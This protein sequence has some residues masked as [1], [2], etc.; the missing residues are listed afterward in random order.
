MNRI[1]CLHCLAALLMFPFQHSLSQTGEASV[2]PDT[3]YTLPPD[4]VFLFLDSLVDVYTSEPYHQITLETF[5][6]ETA[7]E[8]KNWSRASRYAGN[9]SRNYRHIGFSGSGLIYALE[10]LNFAEKTERK[11]DDIWAYFR[12]ANVHSEQQQVELAIS[13]ARRALEIAVER[14]T[15]LEIGWAYNQI[16]EVYR[17]HS[18]YDSAKV[19]YRSGIRIFEE[20]DYQY[21]VDLIT[22]NLAITLAETGDYETASSLLSRELVPL[23]EEEVSRKM[24][25]GIA[26][27]IILEHTADLAEAID[28]CDVLVDFARNQKLV[29]WEIQVLE[30]RAELQRKLDRWEDAWESYRLKDSLK[31]SLAGEKAKVQTRLLENQAEITA[32]S[33]E[34][35]LLLEKQANDRAIKAAVAA[36][37][38]LLLVIALLMIIS[39]RRARKT[40]RA[41]AE[42]NA[43]L[44]DFLAEK[45]TWINLMAHDLKAPLN[46]IQGLL[47]IGQAP[48]TP[49]QVRREAFG[50]IR[51]AVGRGTDLIGQLLELSQIESGQFQ[52]NDKQVKLNQLIREAQEAFQTAAD[53]K[54]IQLESKLPSDPIELCTDPAIVL[55]I[56]ENFLSNAIKFSPYGK[57]ILVSLSSTPE[58]TCLAVTDEGPGMSY[59]DQEKLFQKFTKLS[60]RPTGGESSTG[61]GLSIVKGL[62]TKI[63]ANIE[64]KSKLGQGST[65]ALVFPN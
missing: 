22:H 57:V 59:S 46:S 21:G 28:T 65:F 40:N 60:A 4:Q 11:F 31:E 61:L 58:G 23:F 27:V 9:I 34:R 18:S 29:G 62:A 17:H 43:Q 42:K 50:H 56:L 45:D 38:G 52:V 10:S 33:A 2:L 12:L 5:G 53:T 20:M 16:G 47:D 7:E 55:R 19:N 14:D 25:E 32:I 26:W 48:E 6:L 1:L 37:A 30:K 39:V 51:K 3:L 49:D 15:L 44:D 36:I 8:S 24:E 13:D 63:N 35:N 64:V 41:L 54:N